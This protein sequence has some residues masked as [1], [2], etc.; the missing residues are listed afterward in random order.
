M[1]HSP[2]RV[3]QPEGWV[4]YVSHRL[5]VKRLVVFVHGFTGKAVKTW[6]K[7][8]AA[9][10]AREWWDEADMLFVGYQSL[11]DDITGVAHRLRREL[12][13][14]YPLPFADAMYVPLIGADQGEMISAGRDPDSRY[15][16]LYLVGHSLGGLIIRRALCDAAMEWDSA[17]HK[18][19]E[20]APGLLDGQV[21]LFSPASAGMRA[22]GFLGT[23]KAI[24]WLKAVEPFL[25]RSSAYTDLQP[26]S[27]VLTETR[28]RTEL[29]AEAGGYPSL[30]ARIV[31][32][33]PDHVVI[34]E[35]YNSDWGDT[36][37]DSRTH[38]SVCKPQ[39]ESFEQPWDFV[40]TGLA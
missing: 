28:A 35:R 23:A 6:N 19:D 20:V 17:T 16:E 39:P 24:G 9:G 30:K 5:S 18:P 34:T 12:P 21:R 36:S 27:A 29:L 13:R 38:K 33:N 25:C 32:A 22:A 31:W 10:D 8:P 37:W 1:T 14:F 2:Y 7:F 26:G 15:D 40:E 11:R 3:T 4:L